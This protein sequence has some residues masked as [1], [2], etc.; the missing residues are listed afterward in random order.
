MYAQQTAEFLSKISQ[1]D[2]VSPNIEKFDSQ[3]REPIQ[4]LLDV[5]VRLKPVN[6][7][8]LDW[9]TKSPY[10][11]DPDPIR[12]KFNCEPV[13]TASN[14]RGVLREWQPGWGLVATTGERI[15]VL[16][17]L[18]EYEG[19]KILTSMKASMPKV[20]ARYTF[21][22]CEYIMF[23][24]QHIGRIDLPGL[25][26]FDNDDFVFIPGAQIPGSTE[27]FSWC[28][29]QEPRF[30]NTIGYSPE[31]TF[32]LITLHFNWASKQRRRHDTFRKVN[33]MRPKSRITDSARELLRNFD[34]NY[35]TSTNLFNTKLDAIAFHFGF[36]LNDSLDSR[37]AAFDAMTSC[38][39][40]NQL[41]KQF[42]KA[43]VV[44]RIRFNYDLGAYWSL[45]QTRTAQQ[46]LH[47]PKPAP[48]GKSGKPSTKTSKKPVRR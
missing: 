16:E 19:E 15:S 8:A 18:L 29:H 12:R 44:E 22:N 48:S 41:F 10:K 11:A 6:P 35:L 38:A 20:R 9:T 23:D 31:F 28:E 5:G 36:H 4:T 42:D 17:I 45:H 37:D 40:I 33:P 24:N 21:G 39:E 13:K 34:W 47:V 2:Y 25:R 14:S 3:H 46:A 32:E 7:R 27:T 30:D 26:F 1:P 43:A